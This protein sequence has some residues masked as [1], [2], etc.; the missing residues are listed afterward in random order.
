MHP[1]M[2][3]KHLA[4]RWQVG[5]RERKEKRRKVRLESRVRHQPL[6]VFDLLEVATLNCHY[7][8]VI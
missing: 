2:T 8:N 1:L 7:S 6:Q 4:D 3:E 5:L